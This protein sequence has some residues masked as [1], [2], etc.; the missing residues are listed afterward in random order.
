[1]IQLAEVKI[2]KW[3]Q[4]RAFQ[5]P[6]LIRLLPGLGRPSEIIVQHFSLVASII[7]NDLTHDGRWSSARFW[8]VVWKY[9]SLVNLTGRRNIRLDLLTRFVIISLF[10]EYIRIGL[11]IDDNHRN[12]WTTTRLSTMR[13]PFFWPIKSSHGNLFRLRSVVNDRLD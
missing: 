4:N 10:V 3:W 12:C 13:N 11:W 7:Y 8:V 5:L 2:L 9:T 1:M 6:Y